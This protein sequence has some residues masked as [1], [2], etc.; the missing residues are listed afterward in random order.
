M[1][2]FC[3]II[4]LLNVAFPYA[5]NDS[6]AFVRYYRTEHDFVSGNIL[7]ASDRGDE[8][9][10]QVDFNEKGKPVRK[11]WISS[12]GEI[13][14][15]VL[16][17]HDNQGELKKQAWL[18]PDGDAW[19]IVHYGAEEPWSREFR[20]FAYPNRQRLYFKGQ[21]TQFLLAPGGQVQTIEFQT[22]TNN[23]YGSIRLAYDYRGFLTEEIW[24]EQPGSVRI[25]QFIYEIDLMNQSRK[26]WEFG[27]HD[28]LI[29]H[30]TLE[31]APAD[32]LYLT[33][34]PR[35]GNT[36]D[37]YDVILKDIRSNVVTADIPVLIPETEHD[38]LYLLNGE[39]Y[40]IEIVSV[41]SPHLKFRQKDSDDILT[42]PLKKVQKIV[43]KWGNLVY[44]D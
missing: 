36:L 1:Y 16:L 4:L 34:P 26:I 27:A 33:P 17:Y 29:S 23:V 41:E 7:F 31:M 15:D 19:K 39:T 8:G 6:T 12:S 22:V 18:N 38:M 10:L 42:I 21:K 25:R 30:V 5:E 44:P 14:N 35:T 43:S 13:L 40:L 37:E 9:Y 3:I 32:R 24:F 28:S 20:I 2:R 11:R